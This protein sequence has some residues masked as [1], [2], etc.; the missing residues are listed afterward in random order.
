MDRI[1][2][3][4]HPWPGLIKNHFKCLATGG[5]TSVP[6]PS[7]TFYIPSAVFLKAP[8]PVGLKCWPSNHGFLSF[9]QL[10]SICNIASEKHL[11]RFN[12]VSQSKITFPVIC[13][14]AWT[15]PQP[16]MA[17][18]GLNLKKDVLCLSLT[19]NLKGIEKDI[20]R[21]VLKIHSKSAV[22]SALRL[23]GQGT[24]NRI[25]PLFAIESENGC[26]VSNR[27]LSVQSQYSLTH[28]CCPVC[29]IAFQ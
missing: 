6:S 7:K 21:G 4:G 16:W 23:M 5:Q 9:V 17:C 3:S 2:A 14:R 10:V 22:V 19:Q 15:V 11:A 18:K 28:P 20:K 25:Y 1:Q 8:R 12:S 29:P 13:L 27:E 24:C 26:K